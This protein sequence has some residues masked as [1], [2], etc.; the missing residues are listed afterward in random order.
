MSKGINYEALANEELF[1]LVQQHDHEAFATLYRRYDRRIYAYCLTVTKDKILANDAYQHTFASMY[2]NRATFRGG[3]FEAWLFTIAR[4]FSVRA[5]KKSKRRVSIDER[6]ELVGGVEHNKGP[7]TLMREALVK[8]IASLPDNLRQP[9]EL[10]YYGDCSYDEIA[11]QFGFSLSVAKIRVFR[12]KKA[13]R[14]LL[15]P[16]S[17]MSK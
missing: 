7:D 3:N 15:T 9:L 6:D 12:A 1:A 17:E 8:A 11:R 16:Q 2:E 14:E 4:N 13:L 5:V 10:R